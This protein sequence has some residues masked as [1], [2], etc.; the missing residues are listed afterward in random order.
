M[1]LK[2]I[3]SIIVL[4]SSSLLGYIYSKRSSDRPKDLRAIQGLLQMLENEMSFLSNVLTEAFTKI[5][6]YNDEDVT[7]FFEDTVKI[8]NSDIG[9]NAC[10]A[11][12]KA[13]KG[14]LG[15]TSLNNE[16]EKILLSFGKML[17]KSDIEGQ[18]KNIRLTLNQLG[19]QERKAEELRKKNES[20]YKSLGIL[21][22]LAI[23]ILL[24]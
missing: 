4:L 14:N 7:I 12:E 6:Q 21:G 10:E 23:I 1:T 17:G 13:V 9:V 20:M 8:I 11:W 15:R 22:G 16:D 24:F 19:M 2:I 5:Y 18:I 3:G